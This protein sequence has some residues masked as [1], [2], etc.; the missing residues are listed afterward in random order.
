MYSSSKAWEYV[1][2]LYLGAALATLIYFSYNTLVRLHKEV[3][4]KSYNL[5]GSV[6]EKNLDPEG[7][8]AHLFLVLI[9]CRSN[10]MCDGF[11]A[12]VTLSLVTL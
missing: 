10:E 7:T 9:L 6:V 8:A 5:W 2:I 11:S 12:L 3:S 4:V 1:L